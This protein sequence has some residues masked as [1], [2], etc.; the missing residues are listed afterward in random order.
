[1]VF[2]LQVKINFHRTLPVQIILIL[3]CIRVYNSE[4]HFLVDKIVGDKVCPGA[5]CTKINSST[6]NT[7]G[8]QTDG[9]DTTASTTAGIAQT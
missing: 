6:T 4:N 5:E 8:V 2:Q 1:M 3:I 7:E 9:S